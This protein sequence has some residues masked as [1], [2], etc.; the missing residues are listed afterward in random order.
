MTLL[1]L[2]ELNIIESVSKLKTMVVIAHRFTTV[3]NCDR[4][5]LIDKGRIIDKGRYDALE[6]RNEKFKEMVGDWI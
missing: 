4:I 2:L 3:K 5:Y 1:M 6:E